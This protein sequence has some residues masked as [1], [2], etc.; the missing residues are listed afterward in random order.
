MLISDMNRGKPIHK[1]IWNSE[2]IQAY[3]QKVAGQ[4]FRPSTYQKLYT[5]KLTIVRNFFHSICKQLRL[6]T[7]VD[8]DARKL[9][10]N[11]LSLTVLCISCV[12]ELIKQHVKD[13]T[14]YLRTE[15][16]P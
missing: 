1:F 3:K 2:R 4:I 13:Y 6:L 5:L 10:S 8:N 14:L 16:T 15:L 7:A 12:K 9:V 11:K